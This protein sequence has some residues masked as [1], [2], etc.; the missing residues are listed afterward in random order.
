MPATNLETY[1]EYINHKNLFLDIIGF[2]D[3]R[4]EFEKIFYSI[5]GL[6]DT[7]ISFGT[8]DKSIQA[9]AANAETPTIGLERTKRMVEQINLILNIGA[10]VLKSTR[11][12]FLKYLLLLAGL[13]YVDFSNSTEK[14]L[15]RLK[16][17]DD[18]LSVFFSAKANV[19]ENKFK[20][21]SPEI[22]DEMRLVAL[23]TKGGHSLSRV[24]NR[25]QI[26][27][28]YVN[29]E[30]INNKPSGVKLIEG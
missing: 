6:F 12:R 24:E 27:A 1:L 13:G 10:N 20:G 16:E 11:K 23:L 28:Y 22:I 26:L 2:S 9:Y 5:I 19:I 8:T 17:I 7:K 14:K 15:V 4:A 3:N 18:K 25:M 29:N 21:Y 30:S